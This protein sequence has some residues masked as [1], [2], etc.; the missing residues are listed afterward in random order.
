[1]EY[2]FKALILAVSL[3]TQNCKKWYYLRK[4]FEIFKMFGGLMHIQNGSTQSHWIPF[5]KIW[6]NVW[7]MLLVR[8]FVEFKYE[9]LEPRY[10]T[11]WAQELINQYAI[12]GASPTSLIGRHI[13]L[14]A[15][16]IDHIYKTI[17][18]QLSRNPQ[19]RCSLIR[20][21]V[22]T[23]SLTEVWNKNS[24]SDFIIGFFRTFGLFSNFWYRWFEVQW[25]KPTIICNAGLFSENSV[26]VRYSEMVGF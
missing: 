4:L 15:S 12:W 23:P 13:F 7:M 17:Q 25:K 22:T 2:R 20:H 18:F 6:L 19:S 24:Y 21:T 26:Y 10:K 3:G 1:M 9:I 11:L 8:R 16:S 14:R 5:M